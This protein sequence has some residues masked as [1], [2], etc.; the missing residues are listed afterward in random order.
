MPIYWRGRFYRV[1]GKAKQAFGVNPFLLSSNKCRPHLST[2]ITCR[3]GGRGGASFPSFKKGHQ[4]GWSFFFNI[5]SN[6]LLYSGVLASTQT[7]KM[8]SS[9]RAVHNKWK[10]WC[11][12]KLLASYNIHLSDNGFKVQTDTNR[13]PSGDQQFS[14]ALLHGYLYKSDCWQGL[15]LAKQCLPLWPHTDNFN[16]RVNKWWHPCLQTFWHAIDP[17]II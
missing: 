6:R 15:A 8:A 10:N 14:P 16:F 12:F 5:R 2:Y 3:E 4:S 17:Y 1:S 9:V 7:W 13:L 11:R